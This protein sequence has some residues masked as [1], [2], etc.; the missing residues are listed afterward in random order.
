[1]ILC[2]RRDFDPLTAEDRADPL[3]C[4]ATLRWIIN[5]GKRLKLNEL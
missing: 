3:S 4:L 1:M 2:F 5:R